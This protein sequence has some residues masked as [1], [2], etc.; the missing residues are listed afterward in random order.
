MAR[1]GTALV[2]LASL[3]LLVS[4]CAGA[5]AGTLSAGAVCNGDGTISFGWSFHED[6]QFPAGHPE[7]VGY[8]VLRRSLS[9]CDP[10]VR[11]NAQPFVRIPG[12]S[13]SF[14]YTET[15]PATGTTY[16]YR[17]ILVD[18]DR[19]E[20]IL[21]PAECDCAARDGWASCP[22]FSAPITQGT[23]TD[24]G[25]A[26]FV[27]PCPG[28]CYQS[29]YYEG[30]LREELRPF[31]ATGTVVRFFGRMGC[32]T[33]EGCSLDIDHYDLVPCG[34]ITAA[35]QVSWGRVKVLYR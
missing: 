14:T 26:L 27:S 34:T 20:V 6:P 22:E 3:S 2:V 16:Q 5:H 1:T 23:L 13:Q 21:N 25:W 31:A 35:A 17:V 11:V 8:D 19:R 30:P 33:V 9:A 29:C 18:A 4:L 32:W 15:P 12:V 10:F 7:W 28:S 24:W